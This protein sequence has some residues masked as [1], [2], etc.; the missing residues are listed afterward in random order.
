MLL[1]GPNERD[2]KFVEAGCLVIDRSILYIY[3]VTTIGE[4]RT[5]IVSQSAQ[6]R[7]LPP[8]RRA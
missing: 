1:A 2:I 8:A 7:A 4:E 3:S 5:K 6:R